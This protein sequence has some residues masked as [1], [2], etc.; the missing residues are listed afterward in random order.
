HGRLVQFPWRVRV[1]ENLKALPPDAILRLIAE[2]QDDPREHK[3]DLG[4]G[5]Y[6]DEHG[7][8]PVLHCVK[9]AERRLLEQQETKAYLGSGG[10][11]QFNALMQTL[12]FGDAGAESD[13]IVTLQ[14]PGGSGSLRVAAGLILRAKPDVSVWT[15]DPTWANHVPLLGGAGVNLK[16]Y[17]YY[18]AG[19]RS[20]RFGDML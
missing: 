13:R 4:V 5:V 19:S 1:F 7:R 20:I 3:V 18:D 11:P 2:H 16:V 8:T 12:M 6:R 9:K 17:P 15:S 10:N 14:T